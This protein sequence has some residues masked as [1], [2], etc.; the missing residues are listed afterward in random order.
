MS[1][2]FKALNKAAADNRS[3]ETAEIGVPLIGAGDAPR[4]RPTARPGLIVVAALVA[5]VLGSALL[6][7][8]DLLSTGEDLVAGL[9]GG[10]EPLRPQPLPPPVVQAVAPPASPPAPVAAAIPSP[11]APAVDQP[12]KPVEVATAMDVRPAADA[13]VK[14]VPTPLVPRGRTVGAVATS[15]PRKPSG[16][17]EAAGAR[18]PIKVDRAE[19][20]SSLDRDREQELRVASRG[21]TSRPSASIARLHEAAYSSLTD[22]NYELALKQYQD[23]LQRERDNRAAMLGKAVALQKL[24][25]NNAAQEAYEELLAVDPSNRAA[26]T[27]LLSLIGLSRPEQALLQLQRLEAANPTSLPIITQIG[28]IHAQMGDLPRA[29]RQMQLA[30]S[31]APENPL[32][33]LNLAI[34]YDRA[35]RRRDALPLYQGVLA[36]A[37]VATQPLPMAL[38]DVRR[39][40][41]YLAAGE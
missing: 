22:G 32:Y 20:I 8:D 36:H 19:A 39:R 35:G 1:V 25:L 41:A 27:N 16:E 13:D 34:L 15:S 26:T 28:M 9:T 40:V 30:A 38:D 6:F 2:L 4:R 14:V 37:G 21:A 3:R 24:G 5:A 10:G 23:V 33:K 12:T 17:I 11:A 18:A 7:A 31:L 29:I